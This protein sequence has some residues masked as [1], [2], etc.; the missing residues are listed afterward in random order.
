MSDEPAPSWEPFPIRTPVSREKVSEEKPSEFYIMFGDGTQQ[1]I[2][3]AQKGSARS[4]RRG[5]P[6]FGLPRSEGKLCNVEGIYIQHAPTAEHPDGQIES[7]PEI[8]DGNLRTDRPAL[9]QP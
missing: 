3:R 8:P 7:L 9:D 5:T 4:I 6:F 2:S 1:S